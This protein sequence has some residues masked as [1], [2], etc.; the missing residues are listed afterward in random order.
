MINQ[1][2]QNILSRSIKSIQ[3]KYIDGNVTLY[4]Y[5]FIPDIYLYPYSEI[6]NSWNSN[7][8]LISNAMWSINL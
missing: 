3:T 8:I 5:S 7:K 1:L 6:Q 2:G 4:V